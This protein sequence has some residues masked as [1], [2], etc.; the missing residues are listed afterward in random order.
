[1]EFLEISRFGF[2]SGETDISGIGV[3]KQL[4]LFSG[5]KRKGVLGAGNDIKIILAN[6]SPSYDYAMISSKYRNVGVKYFHGFL[7]SNPSYINRYIVGKGFEWTNNKNLNFGFS[8]V[9]IYSREN[10]PLDFAYLNPIS[11]HL[12]IELNDRFKRCWN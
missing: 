9:V 11:T 10:R 2:N 8:E 1:M 7:E 3:S 5:R 6:K 12:E 4:V